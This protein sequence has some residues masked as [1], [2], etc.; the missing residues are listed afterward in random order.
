MAEIPF[1]SRPELSHFARRDE[2]K[3]IIGFSLPHELAYEI[4]LDFR[5]WIR[6]AALESR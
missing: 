3:N 1:Q 2:G 4:G 6:Q 5:V